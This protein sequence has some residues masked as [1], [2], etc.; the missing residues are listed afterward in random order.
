[1]LQHSRA[2]QKKKCCG[3]VQH[4]AAQML[5]HA[6]GFRCGMLGGTTPGV[7]SRFYTQ[8]IGRMRSEQEP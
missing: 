2:G 7:G 5:Q 6:Q 4:A 1:M 3:M 8:N